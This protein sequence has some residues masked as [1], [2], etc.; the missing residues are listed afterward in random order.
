[1]L[2]FSQS[3]FGLYPN[4]IKMAIA[5]K[6]LLKFLNS[7]QAEMQK[8]VLFLLFIFLFSY[9]LSS[10]MSETLSE[11]MVQRYEMQVSGSDGCTP[12]WLNANKYG[13]S[14]LDSF[15]GYVRSGFERPL[16]VDEGKKW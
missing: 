4:K 9:H 5:A 1:M 3:P 15:N 8:F 12:L 7:P 2:S 16:E 10:L 14:S 11:G 6:Y 13:L